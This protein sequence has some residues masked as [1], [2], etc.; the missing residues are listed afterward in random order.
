M[1]GRGVLVMKK[2]P[3]TELRLTDVAEIV[4]GGLIMAMPVAVTEEVWDLSEELGLGRIL[5]IAAMSVAFIALVIWALMYHQVDPEDREDY[6][7]RV[8][9][10]YGI[11]LLIS[12][13]MLFAIDRLP[14][15]EDPVLAFKRTVLVAVPVSFGGTT[16]DSLMS[17]K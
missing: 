5:I 13:A 6:L 8:L 9:A 14:L 1:Y 4:V 7:R 16:A 11:A 3:D 2:K 15:F 17:R 10:A 12:A